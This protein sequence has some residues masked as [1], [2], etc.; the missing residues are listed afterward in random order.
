M[1]ITIDLVNEE[2]LP[3]GYIRVLENLN[4]KEELKKVG[5][6]IGYNF[7]ILEK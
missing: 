2:N 1:F 6:I 3:V 5:E 4:V 7:E